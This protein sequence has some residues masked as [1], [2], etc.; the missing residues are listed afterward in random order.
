MT[1]KSVRVLEKIR[2]CC[3]NLSTLILS[4]SSTR[5]MEYRLDN[6]EHPKV[7]TEALK[8][9]DARFRAISSRREKRLSDRGGSHTALSFIFEMYEDSQ[10]D[11]IRRKMK[12]YGWTL[13]I[14]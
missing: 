4:R 10:N 5:A 7:V 1:E 9:L 2:D 11:D 14:A 12:S 3:S 8:L 6:L 13:D